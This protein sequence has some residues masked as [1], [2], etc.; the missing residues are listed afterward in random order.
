MEARRRSHHV[1]LMETNQVALSQSCW[2]WM[3][4]PVF[5]EGRHKSV[6]SQNAA[7][8]GELPPPPS[9][10]LLSRPQPSDQGMQAPACT[11][12]SPPQPGAHCPWGCCGWTCLRG[13]PGIRCAH[14][15]ASRAPEALNSELTPWSQAR[16]SALL[17]LAA[18]VSW[19]YKELGSG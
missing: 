1:G 8:R 19:P 16:T 4:G 10:S 18:A 5:L 14:R 3:L 9:C 13:R 2:S 15:E 6:L 7:P 11:G 17:R 12:L